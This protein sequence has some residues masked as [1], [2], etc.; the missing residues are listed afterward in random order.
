VQC[1]KTFIF[2]AKQLR[3]QV[4]ERAEAEVIE[5]LALHEEVVEL[6]WWVAG[7]SAPRAL[8]ISTL[9]FANRV[10]SEWLRRITNSD[11]SSDTP[12]YTAVLPIQPCNFRKAFRC[13]LGPAL[14]HV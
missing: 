8:E 11:S 6:S 4:G 2:Q 1:A 3:K 14:I 13:S 9:T 12:R 5:L 7:C 10:V